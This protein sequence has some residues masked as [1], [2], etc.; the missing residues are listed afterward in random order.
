MFDAKGHYENV[1]RF[2]AGR[3]SVRK[4]FLDDADRQ[5][6]AADA[7]G[8][9]PIEWDFYE[10][11]TLE[12]ARETFKRADFLARIRLVHRDYPGNNEWPYPKHAQRGWARGRQK[13]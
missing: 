11:A 10:E 12:F 7:N 6:K 5:I 4:E 8:G 1:L 2:A 9:R 13:Q 3:E